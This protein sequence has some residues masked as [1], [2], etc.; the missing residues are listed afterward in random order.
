MAT[1]AKIGHGVLWQ[2][3]TTRTGPYT[4]LTVGEVFSPPGYAPSKDTVDATHVESPD[5]FR[6]YIAGL[7]DGGE[8]E[9]G[10]NFIPG[11]QAY[12]DALTDF[13]SNDD[14][15]YRTLFTD[16]T[17]IEFRLHMTG[18]AH[19]V[20]L[21]DK[22][23][24][25]FGYKITGKPEL[26]AGVAPVNQV[27]PAVSGVAQVGQTLTLFEGAWSAGAIYTYQWQELI[28]ATWTNIAGATGRTLVVPGGATIGR[29]L[30][31]QVTATNSA[32]AATA[33]SPGTVAVIA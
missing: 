24:A 18:P 20:P 22:M 21:D 31:G 11:A 12:S 28:T 15:V 16:G 9:V 8:L 27:T 5:R 33:S 17:S 13:H 3:A 6:E 32:G 1:Q 19:E 25:T 4:F 26:K 10:L 7:R 23:V 30:R 2:R 29:S 14:W